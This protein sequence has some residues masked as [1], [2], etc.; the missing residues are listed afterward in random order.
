MTNAFSSFILSFCSACVL[1][2]F[3][4]MLCPSGSMSKPVK[5]L[6]CLCFIGCILSGVFAAANFNFSDFTQNTAESEF[7][8]DQNAA[9]TAEM[10]FSNALTAQNIDFRKITVITDKLQ[11]GS[12]IIS[13]VT[14]YTDADAHTVE[15]VIGSEYYEVKI[16]NE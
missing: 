12:I 8:T 3:L 14:V 1:L 6:F 15:Q 7:V 4:Y 11:D 9:V 16:V 2:G 10:I 13:E 5:Y